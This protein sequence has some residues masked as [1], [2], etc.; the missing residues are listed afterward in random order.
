[1]LRPNFRRL[2]LHWDGFSWKPKLRGVSGASGN[3]V[4][5]VGWRLVPNV[6]AKPL[7][8]HW[9]G[10]KW[11]AI[12]TPAIPKTVELNAVSVVSA[13]DVWSAR[14][15]NGTF[16]LTL[17]EHW[18]GQKWS[19]FPVNDCKNCGCC[20]I[21]CSSLA[22]PFDQAVRRKHVEALAASVQARNAAVLKLAELAPK[23]HL[24]RVHRCV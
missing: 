20:H 10:N 23:P 11:V 18:D 2:T 3:D 8:L 13:S 21:P 22:L 6:S 16:F 4:W 5:A 19:I 12:S 7:V 15:W 14:R 24:A 17:V 9:N 1:M